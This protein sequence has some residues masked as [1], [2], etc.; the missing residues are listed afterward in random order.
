E[1]LYLNGSIVL[2]LD[3][4]GPL[5]RQIYRA[6]R[7]DI[8]TRARAPGER[9]PSTRA[10]AGLLKVSRNTAVL[11]YEQL[12]AEGYLETR[13]G[14][15]GTVVAPV[16][17][18]DAGYPGSSKSLHAQRRTRSRTG[19]RLANAGARIVKSARAITKSLGM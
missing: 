6:F 15:A 7:N 13:I 11:A 14:A 12:L 19:P 18:P 10:L 1:F 16:L 17:P 5:Y 2:Q 8:L 9:V 3:G 4:M